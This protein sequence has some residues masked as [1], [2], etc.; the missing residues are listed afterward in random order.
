M[1]FTIVAIIAV[2]IFLIVGIPVAQ[3]DL[4]QASDKPTIASDK[5]KEI[6]GKDGAKMVLIPAGEFQMGTDSAEMP[7]LVKLAKNQG[8]SDA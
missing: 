6:I 4:Q 3:N 7:E 2:S 1:R 5:P 8:F